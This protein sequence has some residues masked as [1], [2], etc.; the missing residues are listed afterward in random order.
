VPNGKKGDNP[1]TDLVVHDEHS[2]PQEIEAL[3]RRINAVG[4]EH[5]RWPLGEHWP[6]SPREYDWLLAATSRKHTAF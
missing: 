3:L 5:G 6:F 1:L 4:R 2:F